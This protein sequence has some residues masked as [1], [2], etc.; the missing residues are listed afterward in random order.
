MNKETKL[1]TRLG[2]YEPRPQWLDMKISN[3][4]LSLGDL[5][6]YTLTSYTNGMTLYRIVKD[7]PPDPDLVWGETRDYMPMYYGKRHVKLGWFK[8]GKK[9]PVPNVRVRGCIEIDPV[10]QIFPGPRSNR[11]TVS[12]ETLYRVNKVDIIEL[13][14]SFSSLQSFIEQ[15]VRR[16]KGE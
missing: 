7:C 5:V 13:G 16:L 15:E 4:G 12:Y 3:R 1:G 8:P 2:D 10:L 11:R 9:T 14:R 6:T